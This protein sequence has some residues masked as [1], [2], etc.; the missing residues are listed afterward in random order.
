[1][2]KSLAPVSKDTVS[3]ALLDGN[4]YYQ[5]LAHPTS[6]LGAKVPDGSYTGS[7]TVSEVVKLTLPF[8]SH[9]LG[10]YCTAIF[11]VPQENST[12]QYV[13]GLNSLLPGQQDQATPVDWTVGEKGDPVTATD[14]NLFGT[15]QS[16]VP[17]PGN[18]LLKSTYRLIR[19]VS[20]GIHASASAAM[21]SSQGWLTIAPMPR[22]AGRNGLY[23]QGV[24]WSIA[25]LFTIP[26]STTVPIM[27]P[28][29]LSSFW[30]PGDNGCMEY[31]L[32]DADPGPSADNIDPIQLDRRDIGGWIVC[33]HG[34]QATTSGGTLMIELQLNYEAVPS[35]NAVMATS[36]P[37]TSD[38]IALS[39][40]LNAV[41]EKPKVQKG[42]GGFDGVNDANHPLQSSSLSVFKLMNRSPKVGGRPATMQ[43]V[44]EP[45]VLCLGGLKPTSLSAF[46]KSTK[47]KALMSRVNS[48]GQGGDSIS[49]LLNMVL[50]LAKKFLPE[51]AETLGGLFL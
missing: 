25:K 14:A 27:T 33:A 12:A 11:G 23:I 10:G 40:A 31:A 45:N 46:G 35:S 13:E 4:A 5:S 19:L 7:A 47:N 41:E 22:S 39:S 37:T 49:S 29:G 8:G 16:V 36:T 34:T 21:T 48:G 43:L 30:T 50:P 28:G 18:S 26:G 1:M 32:V 24:A 15:S 6:V 3:H 38:P 42:S 20:A 2:S 17:H 51:I 9:A 44:D